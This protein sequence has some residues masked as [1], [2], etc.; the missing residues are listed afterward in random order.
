M[1]RQYKIEV[2][3]GLCAYAKCCTP[4]RRQVIKPARS[5]R[6][7][8]PAACRAKVLILT[9]TYLLPLRENQA[10]PKT[11]RAGCGYASL[12]RKAHAKESAGSI[13][14]RRKRRRVAHA[15]SGHGADIFRTNAERMH[16]AICMVQCRS[17]CK[18]ARV[19]PNGD[20]QLWRSASWIQAAPKC[21]AFNAFFSCSI[22]PLVRGVPRQDC[23][24]PSESVVPNGRRTRAAFQKAKN[25]KAHCS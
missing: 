6:M 7:L 19:W 4:Q 18:P 25:L 11:R 24:F 17:A 2:L 5:L 14:R 13:A 9:E 20:R 10:K 1:R 21:R 23:I 12:Q 22:M 8:H 16:R 3:P 15:A